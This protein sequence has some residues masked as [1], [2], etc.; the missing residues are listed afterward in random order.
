MGVDEKK[1]ILDYEKHASYSTVTHDD[2]NSGDLEKNSN[3]NYRY[4]KAITDGRVNTTVQTDFKSI[5]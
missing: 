2:N 1:P 4:F 5:D 3:S